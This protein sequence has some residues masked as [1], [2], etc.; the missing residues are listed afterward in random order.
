[1]VTGARG[2]C[3]HCEYD[4]EGPYCISLV[5]NKCR[6]GIQ[7]FKRTAGPINSPNVVEKASVQHSISKVQ[8]YIMA[9][10]VSVQRCV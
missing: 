2:N 3:P 5:C 4:Q 6:H 7:N 9:T 1:M 10:F 8:P